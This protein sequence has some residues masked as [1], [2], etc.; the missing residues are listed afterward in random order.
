MAD[1]SAKLRDLFGRYTSDQLRLW[2]SI[3]KAYRKD[4]V[5]TLARRPCVCVC[6]Y[7]TRYATTIHLTYFSPF[8]I[9]VA[10]AGILLSQ[11][12]NF[13]MYVISDC[14]QHGC[15]RHVLPCRLSAHSVIYG[16]CLDGACDV[17]CRHVG[18]SLKSS[19]LFCMV[20]R[21]RLPCPGFLAALLP[22][23]SFRPARSRLATWL[24]RSPTRARAP[25][26]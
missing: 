24:A 7:S 20:L 13:E 21:P 6:M 8:Q 19:R 2:E 18:E 26:T 17:E 4:N 12:V 5:C 9:H 25:R 15:S 14:Y 22:R 23:K 3:L 1:G 16:Y 10:E 11:N